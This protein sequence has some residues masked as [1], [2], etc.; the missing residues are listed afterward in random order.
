MKRIYLFILV[1]FSQILLYSQQHQKL[2]ADKIVANIGEKYIL[3]SD[4]QNTILDFKRQAI[5]NNIEDYTVPTSC[6]ILENL[7]IKKILILQAQRDSLPVSDEEIDAALDVRIRN[8]INQ[9]G[10][11]E[12]LEEV[13]GKSI[14]Q[15]KEDF[16]DQLKEQK[17]FESM[18]AKI[19]E[20]IK[21]TPSE[22][23]EFYNKIPKD[24]L[25][26]YESEVE[27][28]QIIVHPKANPEIELYVAKQLNELRKQLENNP[29]KFDN[30]VKLYS[31][32]PAAKENGGQYNLNR[33][34]KQWDPT[35]LSA[36]FRLKDGQISPVIKSKFGY[37][38]ILMVS[39][40]GDDAIVKHILRIP[41]ISEEETK[42]NIHFL[43]SVRNLIINNQLKFSEAVNKFSDDENSKFSAGNITDRYGSNYITLDNLDKELIIA[44]KKIE[45][46]QF[47][48]PLEFIDERGRKAVRLIYFKNRTT[49]HKENLKDD[50]NKI[51]QRALD[52]KKNIA[53]EKWIANKST[54]F[55]LTIQSDYAD[56]IEIR[57]FLSK[58]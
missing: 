36:S 22:V 13:A 31:E 20:N 38:I 45:P 55:Y 3:Y 39:K 47:S 40:N 17:L 28:S 49:P 32:D 14:F 1:V 5:S 27:L 2:L 8:F 33:N 18:Q 35:F 11:K 44:L 23:V 4:I 58:K 24:S 21:I 15:L 46:G 42:N 43:D 41:P 19:I 34:D 9:F 54:D 56:C 12:V 16:R 52:V 25:Y 7:F 37:H 50:Y 57:K 10:S 26:V 51:A 48:K 53:I 6:Q 30:F 29:K